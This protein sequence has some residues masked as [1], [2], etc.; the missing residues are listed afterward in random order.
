VLNVAASR[1]E[2]L[3]RIIM[4]RTCRM[5]LHASACRFLLI[6]V[7]GVLAAS[8]S[9]EK[10]APIIIRGSNTIGEELAPRIISEHRKEHSAV[11]FD[12][13][14]KGTA[15]G[16]GALMVERCDIA[17]ASRPATTNELVLAKSRGVAFNEYPVGFYTVAVVLHAANPVNTLTRE[18]VRDIFTGQIRN[19]KEVGGPDAAI[20]LHTRD[21]I[22]GTRLGFQE[23]AMEN[24]PYALE[25]KTFTNDTQLL[26]AVSKDAHA[27]G[28][29][30]FNYAAHSGVKAVS[31]DGVP[32][33]ADA[34][35]EG[36]YPYART[37][38]LYT[39]KARESSATRSLIEFIQSARGKEILT[40]MG[41]VP[42]P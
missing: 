10:P 41:F 19:W 18:Q 14:F 36:R 35:N 1:F 9:P 37:L 31:I 2:P 20:H 24:Q 29:C 23:V 12:L 42:V 8:C 26:D 15:Y 11:T 30:G 33:T 5:R 28:Y 4:K 32:P 39:S 7:A 21:P 3:E 6:A 22:S 16:M 13:E 17:A 40:E 25:M 34:V 27:I 38:R